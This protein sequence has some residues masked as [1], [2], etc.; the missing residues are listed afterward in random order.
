[1]EIKNLVVLVG[2]L[3][4]DPELRYTTGGDGVV[5]F[6]LAVNHWG[7]NGEGKPEEKLDGFFNC[8]HFGD[9]AVKFAEDFRKGDLVQITGSLQQ[10]KY[11]VGTKPNERTVSKIEVKASTIG[12]VLFVPKAKAEAVPAI[13]GQVAEAPQPVAAP[14]PAQVPQPA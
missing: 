1:M 7:R 9:T 3:A 10:S 12:P 14:E 5:N 4:A 6:A 11:T 13:S 8:H 2:R